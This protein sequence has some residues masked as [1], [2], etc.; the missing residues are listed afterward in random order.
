VVAVGTTVVRA[1][2]SAVDAGG[3][4]REKRGWTSLAVTAGTTVRAVD[5]LVTGLHEPT[6]SHL[7]LLR[8]FLDEPLLVHAYAQAVEHQYLWHEFGDSMLIV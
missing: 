8:A 4:V 5:A 1:L 6:A 2:E 7:D 3:M